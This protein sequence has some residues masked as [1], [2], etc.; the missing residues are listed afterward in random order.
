VALVQPGGRA[1]DWLAGTT[2]DALSTGAT[3][4]TI[5]QMLS[6]LQDAGVTVFDFN[7]ADLPSVA[8]AKAN[9]GGQLT[10]LITV[11]QL[12]PRNLARDAWRIL[13]PRRSR[14]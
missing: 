7:G 3:Q 9:W 10:P 1:L 11:E 6:D 8:A 12:N 13:K 14:S 5:G 2:V 4:L